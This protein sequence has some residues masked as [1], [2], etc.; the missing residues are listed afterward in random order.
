MTEFIVPIF[1]GDI[2]DLAAAMIQTHGATVEA[3]AERRAKAC[4]ARGDQTACESWWRV[5]AA[6]REVLGF[7]PGGLAN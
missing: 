2:K 1:E 4:Q 6:I 5:A 3:E 7:T